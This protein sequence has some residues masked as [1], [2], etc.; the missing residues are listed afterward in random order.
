[1]VVLERLADGESA[2]DQEI[3]DQKGLKYLPPDLTMLENVRPT[4]EIKGLF[5]DH[6]EFD[7]TIDEVITAC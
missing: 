7:H 6:M 5:W 1:M 2:Q 4:K 3:A